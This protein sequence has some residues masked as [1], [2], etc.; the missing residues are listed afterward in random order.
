MG[1]FCVECDTYFPPTKQPTTSEKRVWLYQGIALAFL[2]GLVVMCFGIPVHAAD[3]PSDSIT[4]ATTTPQVVYDLQLFAT[5]TEV[6]TILYSSEVCSGTFPAYLYFGSAT[7]TVPNSTIIS[8]LNG[9]YS[10]TNNAPILWSSNTPIA[11]HKDIFNTCTYWLTYVPRNIASS[12]DP[13]PLLFSQY[14][15]STA[16]SSAQII[17]GGFTYGE[18]LQIFLLLLVF[19]LLFFSEV[20]NMIFKNGVV[21]RV[22]KEYDRKG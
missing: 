8:T 7:T 3:F 4:L 9:L 1:T 5:S 14:A 12:T 2:A 22:I 6:R 17:V 16:T 10:Q 15:T 13:L 11:A 18:I 19:S 21:V 20:R